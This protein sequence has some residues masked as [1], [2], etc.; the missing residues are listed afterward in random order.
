MNQ[1]TIKPCKSGAGP[2]PDPPPAVNGQ[3]STN[4]NLSFYSGLKNGEVTVSS[5]R[6]RASGLAAM[7]IEI[8]KP[9]NL[10]LTGCSTGPA[11]ADSPGRPGPAP[12][13]SVSSP[14]RANARRSQAIAPNRHSQAPSSL[15]S[16]S[17]T[18]LASRI[19]KLLSSQP[20]NGRPGCFQVPVGAASACTGPAARHQLKPRARITFAL[21]SGPS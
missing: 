7:Q 1:T 5:A 6:P 14:G 13:A 10:N 9:T 4:S 18:V 3:Q 12:G 19:F 2:V 16:A 15:Y 21:S 11:R 20:F 8:P 17:T